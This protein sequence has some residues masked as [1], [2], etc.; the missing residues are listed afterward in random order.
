MRRKLSEAKKKEHIPS[1]III[2]AIEISNLMVVYSEKYN[3]KY[4]LIEAQ[5][6]NVGVRLMDYLTNLR[7]CFFMRFTRKAIRAF[8][9]DL[10]A[11]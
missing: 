6:K 3:T 4:R 2:V 7:P 8:F 9:K 10:K 5:D 11:V 1:N